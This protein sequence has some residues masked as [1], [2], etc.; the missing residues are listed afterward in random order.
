MFNKN[1]TKWKPL[2]VHKFDCSSYLIMARIDKE[3]GM[4][5]FE[6]KKIA[7]A[8]HEQVPIKINTQQAFE[9]LSKEINEDE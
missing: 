5:E 2:Y 4:F 1:N 3:T 7:G 6:N 8:C 9:E